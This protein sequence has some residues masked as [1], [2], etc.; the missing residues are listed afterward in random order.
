MLYFLFIISLCLDF[1]MLSKVGVC[2]SDFIFIINI[3][4]V[5]Y[6]CILRLLSVKCLFSL[7]ISITV[8]GIYHTVGISYMNIAFTMHNFL[9]CLHFPDQFICFKH[10]A[11]ESVGLE[12]CVKQFFSKYFLHYVLV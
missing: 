10:V 2:Y 6:T 9:Y 11:T 1:V 7:S 12:D 3:C 4:T 5:F 8:F